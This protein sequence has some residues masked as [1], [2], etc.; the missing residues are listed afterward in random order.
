MSHFTQEWRSMEKQPPQIP[1]A[2]IER[3]SVVRLDDGHVEE[4][5]KPSGIYREIYWSVTKEWL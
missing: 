2:P 5:W 1:L 3:L 4:W